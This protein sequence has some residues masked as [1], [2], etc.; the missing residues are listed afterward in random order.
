MLRFARWKVASILLMTALALLLIVPSLLSGSSF[1]AVKAALPKWLPV[2]QIVLGLDL[3][4]GA[5]L[6]ME[7]D[8]ADVT[9]TQVTNLRDDVRRILREESVRSLAGG[10]GMQGRNVQMRITDP[11]DRAKVLNRLR[12]LAQPG[13]QNAACPGS[14]GTACQLFPGTWQTINP[15]ALPASRC[16]SVTRRLHHFQLRGES[17]SGEFHKLRLR[18]CDSHPRNH[19]INI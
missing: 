12:Q 7:V 8:S 19:L 3:Q 14:T 16:L 10:I 18:G 13:L 6:L 4:G 17:D 1:S 5:H 9:R 11:A 2:E 15:L